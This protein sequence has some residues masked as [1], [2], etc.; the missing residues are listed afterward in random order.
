MY[1][2]ARGRE[3]S[4]PPTAA[5]TR[6]PNHKDDLA[7][8]LD[9]GTSGVKAILVDN[10][11]SVVSQTTAPLT[12][13]VPSA[14]WS[15][16]MPQDWWTASVAAIR[17]LGRAQSSGLQRVAAI[18]LSG[19]MHGAVFLDRR[20]DPLRPAILWND[21]RSAAECTEI[22][23]RVGFERLVRLTGNRAYPGFQAPK[24]LWVRSHEPEVYRHTARVLLPK[25]YV[26]YHLT[27]DMASEPSDASGTLLYDVAGRRWSEEMLDAL[28]LNSELLPEVVESAM[29]VGGVG[30]EAAAQTGLRE[31]IPVVAGG[32]DNACAALSS[33]VTDEG[34]IMVS[35][36]TSGTVLAAS[37]APRIDREAR[38]H[39]FCHAVERRWYSMGVMLSAGASLTWFR[40]TIMPGASFDDVTTMAAASPAGARGLIFL[41]Y[42]SGERTP[43]ADATARG[44]IFGL[45]LL[46]SRADLARAVMEGIAFAL[47]DSLE[48]MRELGIE[49]QAARLT[50]G[51]AQSRFWVQMFADVWGIPVRVGLSDVGPAFGG[52]LLAGAGAGFFDS[53]ALAAERFAGFGELVLPDPFAQEQY[54]E[55]YARF[56]GLYPA[57]A[58]TF[59]ASSDL[60]AP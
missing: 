48:L 26:N 41:P 59:G 34:E 3:A 57:L 52:A 10:N 9:L 55:V 38:L 30:R 45:A 2:Q 46:H 18:G 4:A 19:Q 49:P 12:L 7:L 8:G 44:V 43:H 39:T 5:N 50:A 31:S 23:D 11:G 28:D 17:S 27:G 32:A 47:R 20:G 36:G 13:S 15:E 1:P 60:G 42:L 24:I 14:G 54:E 25:D 35:V 33:A 16:Q 53:P 21:Q 40:D 56:R 51:G 29:P 6:K 58:G 22:T 37:Q